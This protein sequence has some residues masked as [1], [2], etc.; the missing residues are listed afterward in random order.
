MNRFKKAAIQGSLLLFVCSLAILPSVHGASKGSSVDHSIVV[1]SADEYLRADSSGI[2]RIQHAV[3]AVIH[4]KKILP[5]DARFFLNGK[6]VTFQNVDTSGLVLKVEV[7]NLRDTW[8]KVR[9][10]QGSIHQLLTLK[11]G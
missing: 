5:T 9:S 2:Y 8:L 4:L 6:A 11:N 10:A 3:Y 7:T 1:N